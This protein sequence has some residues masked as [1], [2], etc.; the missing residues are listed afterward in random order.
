VAFQVNCAA[1]RG[2][3]QEIQ[4][5]WDGEREKVIRR[6]HYICEAMKNRTGSPTRTVF[7]GQ[8]RPML[9]CRVVGEGAVRGEE[10]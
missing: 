5:R 4:Q 6:K 3:E 2:P 10:W 7:T 1:R 8:R 9:R